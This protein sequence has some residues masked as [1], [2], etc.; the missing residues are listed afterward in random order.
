MKM[1][2]AVSHSK[3]ITFSRLVTNRQA[4]NRLELFRHMQKVCVGVSLEDIDEIFVLEGT[5]SRHVM[6]DE[7]IALLTAKHNTR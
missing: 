5:Y 4:K 1:A 2:L 6:T 3:K 7:E